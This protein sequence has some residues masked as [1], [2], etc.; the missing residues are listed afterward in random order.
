MSRSNGITLQLDKHLLEVAEGQCELN[1]ITLRMFV[2]H[3]ETLE[4]RLKKLECGSGGFAEWQ[5][6]MEERYG[7][8]DPQREEHDGGVQVDP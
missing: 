3:V 7:N 6:W 8:N 4:N 2:L 1:A 5:S